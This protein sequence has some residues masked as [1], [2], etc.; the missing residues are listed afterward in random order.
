MEGQ[1]AIS[2]EV[3]MAI[4]FPIWEAPHIMEGWHTHT[5]TRAHARTHARTHAHRRAHTH[6]QGVR[7]GLGR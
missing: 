3:Q 1:R 6:T 4:W 7:R 5:H 2:M